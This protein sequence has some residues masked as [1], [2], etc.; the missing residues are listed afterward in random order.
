MLLSGCRNRDQALELS[1]LTTGERLYI[2]HIVTLER[3]KSVALIHRE[4][5]AALLDSLAAAW[6]D[7]VQPDLLRGLNRN[8]ERSVALGEL[9][10]RVVTAVQDSLLWDPGK[11]R[12]HL[13]L[14]DP[15]RPG[16]E[17]IPNQQNN[18]A[19]AVPRTD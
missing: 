6:G 4:T 1:D 10:L 15:N 19:D 16:R 13:P 18:P 7:S 17:R 2:E 3:A 11:N 8:P 12:L 5:G 9:L 14:P